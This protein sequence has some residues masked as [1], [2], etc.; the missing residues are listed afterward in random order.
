MAK[1]RYIYDSESLQYKPDRRNT[2]D[3]VLSFSGTIIIAFVIG[4]ILTILYHNFFQSPLEQRL[5]NEVTEMEF[6]YAELENKLDELS[7]VLA[8]VENRDDNIFR[9]VMGSPPVDPSIR[10]GGR[11]G[12]DRF[13][14]ARISQTQHAMLIEELED[15]ID[16][17]KRRVYVELVSQDELIKLT[18]SKTKQHSSIPAIQPVSNNEL[19][20]I[21]SGFGLRIHPI[22]K[23]IRMHTGI[24]FAAITGAPVYAT[25]DGAISLDEKFDGF[26]K[27]I[28]I[29]HGF[30]YE[31]R[32]AH[33]QG[34]LV[35]E[36]QQV[37]R[38]EQIGIVGNS[39]LSTAPHLHYEV[40]LNG[41][42][43]NPLNYFFLDLSPAE[44]DKVLSLASVQN[45]SMGN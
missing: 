4:S 26:G 22:Y 20:G 36:G 10:K 41:I 2:L 16:K 43:M 29:N 39:G 32:Y 40:L 15:K 37:K 33:L 27:S 8:S 35:L 6:H 42:Q 28:T 44:Y 30:G 5:G 17:L 45:Q 25:A 18:L 34:F 1:I 19:I 23:L 21:A 31:T 14:T 9:L 11:G 13:A 7:T 24:D 3:I 38:G 12:Y